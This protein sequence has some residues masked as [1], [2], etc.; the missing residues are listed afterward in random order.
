MGDKEVKPA[1]PAETVYLRDLEPVPETVPVSQVQNLIE[2][3]VA[4]AKADWSAT[5]V[6]LVEDPNL[7]EK[8]FQVKSRD[9]LLAYREEHKAH[10]RVLELEARLDVA[11]KALTDAVS[12][13]QAS[14]QAIVSLKTDLEKSE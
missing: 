1:A 12:V 13:R 9:M 8:M 10:A 7:T 3:A 5:P 11:R 6:G 4:K 14:E 2:Q